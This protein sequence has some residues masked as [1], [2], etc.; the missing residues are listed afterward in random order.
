[1]AYVAPTVVSV[2]DAVTAPQHKALILRSQMWVE[3]LFQ[4]H[5]QRLTVKY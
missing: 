4:L 2:G 1:M 3:L 5:P